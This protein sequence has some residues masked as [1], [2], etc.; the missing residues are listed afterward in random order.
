MTVWIAEGHTILAALMA[1]LG[2]CNRCKGVG[3]QARDGLRGDLRPEA[4]IDAYELAKAN[5]GAPGVNGQTFEHIES[6]GREKWLQGIRSDLRDKSGAGFAPAG[7][8]D[9]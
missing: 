3:R 1:S 5:K 8:V 9:L 7:G 4:L 6:G 2:V